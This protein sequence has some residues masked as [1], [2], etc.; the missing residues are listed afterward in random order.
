MK[1]CRAKFYCNHVIPAVHGY[2]AKAFLN[3]VVQ[4]SDGSD[5]LENKSFSDAT[6]G[7]QLEIVISKN[8]PAHKFF[9]YGREYYLDFTRIPL[10]KN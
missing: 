8:V 1:K 6:P 2:D 9:Q 5:C 3:P 4:N 7:G 10:K